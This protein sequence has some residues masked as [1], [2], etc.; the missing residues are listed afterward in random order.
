[1][2]L[3]DSNV[4]GVN[5]VTVRLFILERGGINL[6]VTQ[7]DLLN[8][9]NRSKAFRDT[10]NARGELPALRLDSGEVITEITAI[11][12]YLDEIAVGGRSM[13]GATPELRAR[14]QMWT[15]RLYLEICA[16]M[17]EWWRGSE[18]AAR[19]Y[20]GYRSSAPEARGHNMFEA[21]RGLNQFEEDLEGRQFIAGDSLTMA[22]ILLYAF[23]ATMAPAVPWLHQPGRRNVTAWFERMTARPTAARM[24]ESLAPKVR[25]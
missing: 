8:L 6:D 9:E 22:D 10:V 17:V 15:R 3:Y 14:T 23:M 5:P 19:F 24:Y 1:M 4:P 18:D 20:R 7:V 21:N 2:I 16:P 25:S 13:F 12:G 11:C